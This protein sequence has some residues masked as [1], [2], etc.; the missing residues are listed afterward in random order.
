MQIARDDQQ[1]HRLGERHSERIRSKKRIGKRIDGKTQLKRLKVGWRADGILQWAA[2]ASVVGLVKN[3]VGRADHGLGVAARIPGKAEA[4]SK[5]CFLR[6]NQSRR[7]ARITWIQQSRRGVR[8]Y[9][10]LRSGNKKIHLIMVFSGGERQLP[11]QSH[12]NGQARGD[13]VIILGVSIQRSIANF[14]GKVTSALQKDHRI[15]RKIVG[16][17]V[18]VEEVLVCGYAGEYKKAVGSDAL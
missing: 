13:L 14:A 6:R 1:C 3:S 17:T 18:V 15:A 2:F 12:V 8:N 5:R 9:L 7:N 11:T 10:R 16:K 4:R